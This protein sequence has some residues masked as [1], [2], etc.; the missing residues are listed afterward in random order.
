MEPLLV[1][2][3]SCAGNSPGTDDFPAQITVTR[4]FDVSSD[5]RLNKQLSKQ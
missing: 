5:L 4:S 3:V 2:L 1:S